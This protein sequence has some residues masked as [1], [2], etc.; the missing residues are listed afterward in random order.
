[1]KGLDELILLDISDNLVTNVAP[2]LGPKRLWRLWL[3]GNPPSLFQE[4]G[5]QLI[6][7]QITL[8]RDARVELKATSLTN[9]L[10]LEYNRSVGEFSFV[11]P[12]G[13]VLQ[14]SADLE[15]WEDVSNALAPFPFDPTEDS[16]A[17]WRLRDSN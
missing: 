11:W 7:E 13:W 4:P 5:Q 15:F 6:V 16:S 17:Y 2:L 9:R 1:M 10:R 8:S 14:R 12:E 3:H